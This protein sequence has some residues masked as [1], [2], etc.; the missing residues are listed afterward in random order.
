[1]QG[2]QDQVRPPTNRMEQTNKQT[3]TK[4]TQSKHKIKTTNVACRIFDGLS[5]IHLYF[6]AR[7]APRVNMDL[8]MVSMADRDYPTPEVVNVVVNLSGRSVRLIVSVCL[9]ASFYR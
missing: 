8:L 5:S 4:Q 7:E 3:N 6:C 2:C 9:P 1:M